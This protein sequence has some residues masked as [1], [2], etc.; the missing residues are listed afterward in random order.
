[1]KVLNTKER[2]KKVKS[3]EYNRISVTLISS[4]I[5]R[6]LS[7]SSVVF[8]SVLKSF[9]YSSFRSL[10]LDICSGVMWA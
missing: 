4:S 7:V 8:V 10:R 1:M 3:Y 2:G 5:W 9:I 6:N